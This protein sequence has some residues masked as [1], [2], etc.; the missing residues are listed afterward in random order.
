MTAQEIQTLRD[1]ITNYLSAGGFFNPEH[2]EHQKVRDLLMDCRDELDT[3]LA[4][5]PSETPQE[6]R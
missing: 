6:P 5:S 3:L 4:H 1:R 2:M